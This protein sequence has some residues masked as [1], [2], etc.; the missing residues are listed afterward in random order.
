MS[1]TLFKL[2][3]AMAPRYNLRAPQIKAVVSLRPEFEESSGQSLNSRSGSPSPSRGRMYAGKPRTHQGQRQIETPDPRHLMNS[4]SQRAYSIATVT[5]FEIFPPMDK[6]G[7]Y[8]T[9][10]F[11]EAPEATR[12]FAVL[13]RPLISRKTIRHR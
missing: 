5:V 3:D 7:P 9:D 6:R 2:R 4:W 12:L 11:S 8:W 13:G 10:A 1:M